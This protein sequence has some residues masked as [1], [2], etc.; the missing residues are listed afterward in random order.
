MSTSNNNIELIQN[1]WIE[2][3]RELREKLKAQLNRMEEMDGEQI[4]AY[5]DGV[6]QAM[7]LEMNVQS[8]E[9]SVEKELNKSPFDNDD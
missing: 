3:A 5:V 9:N 2:F 8:F 1:K 6:M 4:G 7:W